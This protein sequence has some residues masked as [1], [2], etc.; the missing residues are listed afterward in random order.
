MLQSLQDWK[1]APQLGRVQFQSLRGVVCSG[2]DDEVK[3]MKSRAFSL[4]VGPSGGFVDVTFL[5]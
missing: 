3:L 1:W 4:E 2:Q 5:L